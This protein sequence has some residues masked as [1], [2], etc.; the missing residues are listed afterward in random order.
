MKKIAE[1]GNVSIY[2]DCMN[3]V[4]NVYKNNKFLIGGKYK[5]SEVEIYL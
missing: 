4:Y 1:K 2:F 5:F 3:Q